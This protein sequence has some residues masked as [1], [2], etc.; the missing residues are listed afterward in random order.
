LQ[1]EPHVQPR[2]V[3]NIKQDIFAPLNA[4]CV[5]VC[6][7][8]EDT[9]KWTV[10][11]NEEVLTSICNW[12]SALGSN[13]PRGQQ[14]TKC[15]ATFFVDEADSNQ[16]GKPRLD[17]VV[18]F[19]NELQ[20]R[21][22]SQA[23]PIWSTE[24]QP[25]KAMEARMQLMRKQCG[26][27]PPKQRRCTLSSGGAHSAADSSAS[28]QPC[29]SAGAHLAGETF[30]LAFA[31]TGIV[32]PRLRQQLIADQRPDVCPEDLQRYVEEFSVDYLAAWTEVEDNRAS[33]KGH[34]HTEQEDVQLTRRRWATIH[35][36]KRCTLVG[37]ELH[38]VCVKIFRGLAVCEPLFLDAYERHNVLI[39]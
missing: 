12:E 3:I 4:K 24:Q 34:A 30:T 20:V 8:N 35:K 10:P 28:T 37:N 22:H 26:L 25:T 2:N 5:C 7:W 36:L 32:G 13:Y 1:L 39:A 16:D 38:I 18:T 15:A 9:K 14:V 31:D 21:F 23:K 27:V 33:W 29:A 17:I 6:V 11:A 19:S